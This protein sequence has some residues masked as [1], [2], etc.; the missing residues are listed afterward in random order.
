MENLFSYGTLQQEQVQL[1]T[2]GRKLEGFID[3]LVGYSLSE[4]KIKDVNVIESSGKEIHPIVI[5]TGNNEHTVSGTV[6]KITPE[7]L[8]QSD[9]YEV[10]DYKRV[11]T[12]LKS[13]K[14]AWVYI[15]ENNEA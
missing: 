11:I 14:T 8:A 15:A 1:D 12:T 3:E 13:G 9:K 7:E 4:I 6:F 5:Y 10:E 2:F